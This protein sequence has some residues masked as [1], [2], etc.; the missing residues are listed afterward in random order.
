MNKRP[1]KGLHVAHKVLFNRLGQRITNPNK[2]Q[3]SRMATRTVSPNTVG[4]PT[5]STHGREE[6]TEAEKRSRVAY[7]LLP[8]RLEPPVPTL[9]GGLSLATTEGRSTRGPNKGPASYINCYYTG[10]KEP[11]HPRSHK[12]RDKPNEDQSLTKYT[13]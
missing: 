4:R 7:N 9:L 2:R 10:P 13:I 12:C 3:P 11:S 6:N 1:N 8:Y 5:T